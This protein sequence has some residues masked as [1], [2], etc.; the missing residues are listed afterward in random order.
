LG[1][2]HLRAEISEDVWTEEQI[3]TGRNKPR[4]LLVC[5]FKAI[6]HAVLN[7]FNIAKS[8]QDEITDRKAPESKE[9]PRERQAPSAL[10][11]NSSLGSQL[12]VDNTMQAG[13]QS[14]NRQSPP[15]TNQ[16]KKKTL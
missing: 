3:R 11:V 7:F 6:S 13:R 2:P 4:Q 15:F 16:K 14:P 5:D 9:Q 8:Y 1:V 12:R 10:T